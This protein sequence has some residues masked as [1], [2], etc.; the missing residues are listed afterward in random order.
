MT[1]GVNAIY[2]YTTDTLN[3]YSTGGGFKDFQAIVMESDHPERSWGPHWLLGWC[4][5]QSPAIEPRCLF[6]TRAA[7]S[8]LGPA[9]VETP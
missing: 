3:R 5:R 8:G 4:R 9:C 7:M 6:W 2:N 1:I